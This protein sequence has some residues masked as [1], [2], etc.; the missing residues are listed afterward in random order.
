M[1]FTDSTRKVIYTYDDDLIRGEID[2]RR[3]WVDSCE[4]SGVP[5]GLCI[6]LDGCVWSAR[7]DGWR[8]SRYDHQG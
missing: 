5:D 1:N 7:W 8:I 6:D 2:R 4:E 3:V